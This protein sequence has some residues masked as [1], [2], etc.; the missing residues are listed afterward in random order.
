MSPSSL[1][2]PSRHGLLDGD[3][4][5]LQQSRECGADA[6]PRLEPRGATGG[7]RSGSPARRIISSVIPHELGPRRRLVTNASCASRC[8]RGLTM[9]AHRGDDGAL[10]YDFVVAPGANPSAIR[11]RFEGVSAAS[12]RRDWRSAADHGSW[13]CHASPS[14][15]GPGV[16]GYSAPGRRAVSL[17]PRPASS[18]SMSAGKPSA[19]PPD[20]R[21]DR[22]ARVL[23]FGGSDPG[24][25]NPAGGDYVSAVALDAN[26]N[27][28]ITG[29]TDLDS[30]LVSGP[31]PARL[32]SRFA[33]GVQDRRVGSRGLHHAHRRAFA[34]FL[35]DLETPLP[36]MAVGPRTSP[37][38]P[39]IFFSR[40]L[41]EPSA[42]WVRVSCSS[43]IRPAR[44]SV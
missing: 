39:T 29:G 18:A 22:R 19:L 7:T 4:N 32:E 23:D 5:G 40:S 31:L 25:P 36:W 44:T 30:I 35:L 42:D 15:R 20:A 34:E 8:T 26:G 27:G 14:P 21:S 41:R 33:A 10:A 11:L 24:N 38:S 1:V 3:G 16:R 12:D 37:A 43:W 6:S 9:G 2:D 13:R 28:Y 17:E